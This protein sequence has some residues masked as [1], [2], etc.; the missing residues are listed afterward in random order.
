MLMNHTLC[1]T[2]EYSFSTMF[3]SCVD[4]NFW[5]LG[6]V[7]DTCEPCPSNGEC[8]GG[9]LECLQGYRKHGNLCVEDGDINESAQKIVC[10]QNLTSLVYWLILG[11]ICCPLFF[12]LFLLCIL[13]ISLWLAIFSYD[14]SKGRESGISP[15]QRIF[16]IFVL[17]NWINLG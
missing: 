4:Y 15:L 3:V 9:K 14:L 11:N 12:S 17:W 6:I 16:S 1:C 5:W 10:P 8:H 2:P 7:T 13:C